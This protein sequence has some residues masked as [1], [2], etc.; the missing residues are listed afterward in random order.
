MNVL[1]LASL[2]LNNLY[3]APIDAINGKANALAAERV[4]SRVHLRA[5]AALF[6]ASGVIAALVSPAALVITALIQLTAWAYSCP[7]ARLK[8]FFGLNT[9]VIALATVLAILLGFLWAPGSDPSTAP[10]RFLA[11]LFIAL[12][13]AFHVKDVNDF[14]GDKAH[15]IATVVTVFGERTGRRIC[16]G[17]ALC[18]YLTVTIAAR[19]PALWLAAAAPAA[20]TVLAILLPKGKINEPLVFLLLFAYAAAFMSLV[21]LEPGR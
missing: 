9:A 20:G 7:P 14:P 17:L 18:G 2:I 21:A 13:L 19:S 6:V 11:V 1:F 15:G 4:P 3:D 8:R 16:A 12:A 10:W 5:A